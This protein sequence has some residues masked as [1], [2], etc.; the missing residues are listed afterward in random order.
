[1]N[2]TAR[3]KL[4]R[5]L[6]L[7]AALAVTASAQSTQFDRPHPYDVQNYLIRLRFDAS[8]K[9]LYGDTTVT[10]T[11]VGES[12]SNVDLDGVDL[13]FTAIRID[14][15]DVKFK[16]FPDK[17]S[18]T[19]DKSYQPGSFLSINF[20]YT[21]TD[22]KKG[23]Y[24][25]PAENAVG[26]M[27]H[28][29]QI[30]SQNEPEDARY[31]FPSFDFPSDKATSE[32]FITVP[33]GEVVI[34]NGK[35]LGTQENADGTVTFHFKMD[36]PHSTYL[37]SFV[38]GDFTRLSDRHNE[39]PLAF[40]AYR[41]REHAAGLAFSR[42]KDMMTAFESL[43]G[44]PFPFAKYDQVMVSGF[45]EFDGMENVTATTLA[46][47]EILFAEYPF[48]R[49]LVENLVSHELA[50]SWFGDMVTCRNWSE[51][52]LNEGFATF[53]EAVW[54]E[55]SSGE[56]GY[57]KALREDLEVYI[58][59][60]AITKNRHALRNLTAKPNN[61]LFDATTYQ[62]G[63]LV[64]HMLRRTVGDA[65][66]WKGINI[67]LNAHKFD[68][69]IS[70]DLQQAM[71]T[72]SGM[73]LQVF[74]D[75]WVYS[76]GYPRLEVQQVYDAASQTEKVTITQ[77]QRPDSGVPAAFKFPLELEFST[78]GGVTKQTVNISNRTETFNVKLPSAPT[79]LAVD[80][81]E[82]VILKSVKI[83]P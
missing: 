52:W 8:K 3:P 83:R 19:L 45:Q 32:E 49:P 31:W 9:T 76:P 2:L 47:T 79:K 54:R 48:G 69:V 37:T 34:G 24:F 78:A 66:F 16:L 80:K 30:W 41:D 73:R 25:I 12:L 17:V 46:D 40:Y 70:S 21:T 59:D 11:P 50:H 7:I 57:I 71:E 10:L 36:V 51:L 35:A 67:Y 44:V 27:K 64:I 29:S 68:S 75:Q 28:P 81:Q 58:T 20:K 42:T 22:P 38:V 18:V 74:F 62:K 5:R 33:K 13:N 60:D 72:A 23:V 63:G 14:G 82:N 56:D 77:T 26:K 1:M 53:M 65:A 43:T 4:L 39:I 6:L 15:K 61:S 55:H